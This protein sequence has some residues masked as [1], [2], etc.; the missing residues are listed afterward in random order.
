MPY[1][2]EQ[3]E[4]R[5]KLWVQTGELSQEG[6]QELNIKGEV[7]SPTKQG[8]PGVGLGGHRPGRTLEGWAGL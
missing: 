8:A 7:V 5:G 2:L 1:R 6:S 3:R 4:L